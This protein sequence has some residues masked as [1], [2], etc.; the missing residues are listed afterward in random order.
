GNLV[1]AMWVGD[2]VFFLSDHEGVGNIYSCAADGSDL[3]RRT[4]ELEYYARF[5]STDGK[6]VVYTAGARIHVLD[7]AGNVVK[8]VE[9]SVPSNPTQAERKFVEA[10]NHLQE[11]APHPKG[12]SV[13]LI[14]RGQPFTMPL[15]EGAV[16]NH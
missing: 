11:F 7:P 8:E 10:R 3:R 9:V 4:N 2:H 12:H 6:N 5:P 1:W 13:L 15:W 16:V 14:A